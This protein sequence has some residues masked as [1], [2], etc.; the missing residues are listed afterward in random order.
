[1]TRGVPPISIA[2]SR[3][4]KSRH[5]CAF[6]NSDEEAYRVLMPFITDGFACGDKAIHVIHPDRRDDHLQ[7]LTAAGINTAAAQRRGQL[8]IRNN[9]DTYL[10]DGR[11]DQDRML[12]SFEQLASGNA[13]GG[14]PLSRIVCHMDWAGRAH[15]EDLV[16]FEARVNDV[17]RRHDDAVICAYDLAK[18]GGDTIIDIMRTHPMVIIGGI[19]QENP[20]FIPPDELLREVRGRPGRKASRASVEAPP[21]EDPAEEIERLRRC[22]N[23]LVSALALPAIWSGGEERH[24]AGTLLDSLVEMLRLDLFYVRLNDV[25]GGAP[26]E[27]VRAAPRRA[28]IPRPEEVGELISHSLPANRRDWPA[29][30]RSALG[31]GE[32]TMVAFPLGL[33]GDLGVLVAAAGRAGFPEETERLVLGVA[34]NQAYIAIREARLLGEQT[35]VAEEL[36]RRVAWRTAELAA[37]NEALRESERRSRTIVDSIPGLVSILTPDGGVDVVNQQV[38]DYC[39][40]S[41]EELRKWGT[42]DTVHPEDLPYVIEAFS[43]SIALGIPYEIVQRLRRYDGVYR[44]FLNCGLPYFDSEGRLVQW[45]VLLTDIDEQKRAEEALRRSEAFL[46]QGQRVSSTGTFSWN[47]AT[48]DILWSAELYRIFDFQRGSQVTLERIGSRVYADDIPLLHDMIEGAR[49]GS[50]FESEHRI[51]MPDQ[52]VKHIHLVAHSTRNKDGQ[53]EYMGAAQDVTER[54]L[55]EQAL[56]KVSSELAHVARALSL[57]VLTASIAHEVNQPLAGIITNAS[58]CLRFLATEP[59]NID[60]ARETARRTIRDGNRASE[61]IT[62][63]RA[64]FCKR[65]SA[66]ESVDL[67][68]AT[69]E[70]I[71][72]SLSDL[73]RGR[74]LLRTE[75]AD[76]LP[77][78]TGDRV[79]LQQVILNL[80]RNATDA[81]SAVNDRPRQLVVRTQRAEDGARLSVQD[82][83]VGLEPRGADKLFEP[84]F[85]TK[86]GG[87]GIG[88]SVSRSIIENHQG[89]LWAEANEGPGATFAFS[90]PGGPEL[91]STGRAP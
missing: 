43:R 37:V 46:A 34:A 87:M 74:V 30:F 29:S 62:R 75:L 3:L 56:S 64:L 8:E 79:Q 7:R 68:E 17:W 52:S 89:R 85:T 47:V 70:V 28:P 71:A 73:Q 12:A 10:V 54:K 24:I 60:G 77:P 26:F 72:L 45:Y 9:T 90:I 78:I 25:L 35:R 81:M 83:G 67:N 50:D 88:L 80:V 31:D 82:A 51:L 40:R 6:F 4:D 23:D 49:S 44:W 55:S 32:V 61:V 84:F 21:P 59:P 1:M 91:V 15:T 41:L 5:V 22:I 16:E 69:R 58:T 13:P 76:D 48:G 18:F 57:G 2:G 36:D 66:A 27:A 39:G 86:T 19:L 20:F 63:L 14:F 42:G 33:H 65:D 11:F 38:I 53:L